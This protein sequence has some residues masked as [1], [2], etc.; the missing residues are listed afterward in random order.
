MIDWTQQWQQ[1]AHNFKEGKS[2]I[3]LTPF[4][5]TST[6]LLEPGPGFGDLSHPTTHLM[7]K[8]LAPLVPHKTVLDIGCGSGILTLAALLLDAHSAL[9]I[10]ID[11]DAITH[12]QHNALL[13]NLPATFTD[14]TPPQ[15]F[16]V[17]LI[18]MI[19]SEQDV[20]FQHP[21]KAKIWVV[22]GLLA[23]QKKAYLASRPGWTLLQEASQGEWIGLVCKAALHFASP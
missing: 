6:L 2:H 20:V 23:T 12:A 15:T 7:L 4:G 5:G 1:F 18:N 16:D 13:N 10:D 14:K 22:S 19:T 9:G 17:A 8:L 11:P 21:P 3:D